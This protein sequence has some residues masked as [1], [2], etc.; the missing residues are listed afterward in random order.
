MIGIRI[1]DGQ[2]NRAREFIQ[3]AID[4]ALCNAASAG[5]TPLDLLGHALS[6]TLPPAALA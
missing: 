3:F 4:G 1:V 5:D 6:L 2:H